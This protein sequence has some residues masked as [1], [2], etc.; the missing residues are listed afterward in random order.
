MRLRPHRGREHESGLLT[1]RHALNFPVGE[2]LRYA[3]IA[4]MRINLATCQRTYV[5]PTLYGFHHF[6]VIF[7]HLHDVR[8]FEESFWF[9]VRDAHSVADFF[10]LITQLAS[11]DGAPEDLAHAST[12]LL[13]Y[14]F[15]IRE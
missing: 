8:R 2:L 13:L 9:P 6:V 15:I 12:R 14:F 3:K 7:A 11:L 4:Q 5:H 1:A 10:H